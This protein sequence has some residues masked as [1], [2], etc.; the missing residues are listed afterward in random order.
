MHYYLRLD[1]RKGSFIVY[2]SGVGRRVLVTSGGLFSLF[3]FCA[4]K[5][6]VKPSPSSEALKAIDVL[7]LQDQSQQLTSRSLP[8]QA[9]STSSLTTVP[10]VSLSPDNASSSYSSGSFSKVSPSASRTTSSTTLSSMADDPLLEADRL[11][12]QVESVLSGACDLLRRCCPYLRLPIAPLEPVL[13]VVFNEG[14]CG[15]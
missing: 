7:E 8:Q 11:S 10:P 3:A 5:M 6:T 14:K 9:A 2:Y 13:R 15:L 4:S 12:R 1:I